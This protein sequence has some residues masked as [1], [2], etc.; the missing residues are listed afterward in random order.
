MLC[1]VSSLYVFTSIFTSYFL[2]FLLPFIFPSSF[3]SFRFPHPPR[4]TL[5]AAQPPVQ[6]VSVHSRLS[7]SHPIPSSAQVKEKVELYFSSPP[8]P[9]WLVQ[10]RTLHLPY[11]HL[12][13]SVP[14]SFHLTIVAFLFTVPL[15]PFVSF[16]FKSPSIQSAASSYM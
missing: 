3:I 5:E 16:C 15:T 2:F 4:P 9:L 8:G 14:L 1:F 12:L 7:V 13:N 6:W 11:F 10:W